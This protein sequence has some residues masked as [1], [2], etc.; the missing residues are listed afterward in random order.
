ME[1]SSSPQFYQCKYGRVRLLAVDNYPDWSTSLTNFLKADRT[2]KIVQGIETPPTP[3]VPQAGP[4]RARGQSETQDEAFTAAYESYNEK[5]E[6]YESRSA[7]ACSMILSSVLLSFQQFIYAMTDPKQMWST[8]KT[9]LDSINV[10]AGL[11]ILQAQF[12]RE[13]HSTGPISV[14]FAK[15]IQYQT[16]LS[17]TDFK[18]Q[19]IDLISYILL[20]GTLPP[21]FDST[22]EVLC[23]QPNT[24]WSALIQI[25]INKEIE[26]NTLSENP[27]I[28]TTTAIVSNSRDQR[29]QG[30]G[31]RQKRSKKRS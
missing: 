5:Q 2:W 21:R 19:D 9:Q 17:S 27:N 26:M 18:I 7:K 10:N 1:S 6:D 16:C 31:Q 8:L 30:Q 14:F 25:L 13:K 20:Y 29:N 24:N 11:Y 28:T 23:L 22:V 12:F 15:L 3:P 4:S